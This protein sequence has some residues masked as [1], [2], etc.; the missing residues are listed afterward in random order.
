M[1]RRNFLS[2]AGA[3]CGLMIVKP[4]TAF[5]YE[6]NSAVR[7]ALLGCG[8][9]GTSVATSFAKNTSARIVALGDIF[10]DQLA[11]GKTYFDELNASLGKGAIDPKLLFRGHTACEQL[12]SSPD[13]DAI[14]ISTPPFFHVQHLET[15]VNAGKH[16]YC[17][18]PV[19]VDVPQTQHALEIAKRIGTKVSIDVGFQI[20][21]AP[22]FVEIVK[23]IHDGQIGKIASISAHYNAPA[24]TYPDH[25]GMSPDE[26]RLREWLWDAKISGDILLEQNIHVIDVCNWVMGTHPVKAVAKRSRKVIRHA[27]DTSDNYEVIFTYPGEVELSFSSTQFGNNGFFD[28]A[29]TIFG[30]DGVAE[31]P[32]SGPLRI[33]GQTPWTWTSDSTAT[34]PGKFAADGAFTDNLALADTRKDQGF[35]ESITSGKPHNQIAAGVESALSCMLGR[36]AAELGREVTWDELSADR[37]AYS[38]GFDLRQFN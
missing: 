10:P 7:Y 28:V 15:I 35:I 33:L 34:K 5:G 3:A 14:Q 9:R 17:E 2:T 16:S 6:A 22:P 8:K 21:S 23:R 12:A 37:E 18:K 32:Y 36:K 19:G 24:S 30:T 29:E 20:R 31:A 4:K 13:V 26:R 25:S 38:L 1:N 27:G 11:K